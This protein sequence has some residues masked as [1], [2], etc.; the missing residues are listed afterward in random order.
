[1][2]KTIYATM[3]FLIQIVV[4]GQVPEVWEPR[5]IGGG[6]ALFAPAV[7]PSNTDEYYVACDMSEQFHTTDFGLS[8]SN[9]DFTQLTAFNSSKVWFTS[10]PGLLYSINFVT[11]IAQVARSTDN[12]T[13]WNNVA[14]NL[15]WEEVYALYVDYDHPDILVTNFWSSVLVSKNGGESFSTVYETE[16]DPGA[17]LAGVFFD[18]PDIFIG[19]NEG[20]L[21]SHDGGDSFAFETFQGIP[22]GQ[23]FY[24]FAGAKQ[25][26]TLRFF[27]ATAPINDFW[28]SM[29]ASEYW[30]TIDGIYRLDYGITNWEAAITGIDFAVD[31]PMLVAM[32]ANDIH[33]VFLGGS[34]ADG[35]PDV[36]KTTNGGN[37]W[38]HVFLTA[39]N[40]NI[41]TGWSGDGG[42]H[43]WWYPEIILGI[44][45]ARFNPDIVI[46]TDLGTI[47]KTDNGGDLWQ[48]AYVSVSDQHLAGS[49]T[50][51]DQNY[52][53][54]GIENTGAWCMVWSDTANIF[55]GY[56]DISGLRS[57][58]G[59]QSWSFDYTGHDQ[60]TMYCTVRHP[61]T[62]TI[63]AATST[64]HDMY[65]SYKLQDDEIEFEGSGGMV[66]FS[67]D[68]GAHWEVLHD[69]EMP[70]YWVALDPGDEEKL[71]AAVVNHSDGLGGIWM[72]GNLS[73]AAA[74]TWQKLPDP[75]RT[76]GHPATMIV[77]N[78]GKLLTSWSGRRDE[79]GAFTNSSGIFI[80]NPQTQSWDDRS[81]P[82]MDYWTKDVV[83]DPSDLQQ[84]TW[85]AGV[86]SGWGGPA[87]DK[88]GLYRTFD[89]GLS[90]ERVWNTHRVESCTFN[91]LN[92]DEIFITTETKG[93]WHCENINADS[94]IIER[95]KNYNF[96]HPVRVVYNPYNSHEIWV[97]S[98][99]NGMKTG[100]ATI[101]LQQQT[102][103]LQQGW[104]GISSFVQPSNTAFEQLFANVPELLFL[105]DGEGFYQPG[106][107]GN[108]IQNW[109]NNK[110]YLVKMSEADQMIFEGNDPGAHS[111]S[112]VEGWNLIPVLSS[113]PVNVQ[114]M[115]VQ[116][117][118]VV[119]VK[120]VAGTAVFWPGKSIATLLFLLPGKSYFLKADEMFDLE[121][122]NLDY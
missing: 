32:A 66:I 20:L 15:E 67:A 82:N 19:L 81:D 11:D 90:W 25:N 105:S 95:V 44:D 92:P 4:S 60:N 83:T 48:Q 97:L 78:D 47:H 28:N 10:T 68:K 9:V 121:F 39:N 53:S 74:S 72:T 69:F 118:H 99:G 22:D 29:P 2:T 1:M 101:Q 58:D 64:V 108:T 8:Y 86:F 38:Q 54:I 89:R 21:V 51:K 120:D 79:S 5:G 107:A 62:G 112:V 103:D 98:F 6:G 71:Y 55:A 77:L 114:Q 122:D 59:G 87:N 104:S 117:P 16:I 42:D 119:A 23:G 91:P 34:N 106:S 14:G 113:Q 110:G 49:S 93:L 37:S 50:P 96:M 94:P 57:K 100:Y 17:H 35:F 109:N 36:L 52:H 80:Y 7:N 75:P 31:Y 85:Y 40:Q 18:Y 46:V 33:T 13:T 102:V 61:V 70:V 3:F 45:V 88:G 26:D 116:Y 43:Q 73:A 63:F 27:V 56:T 12:G 76:E 84:N 111:V 65:Q 115:I 41:I 30:E 24:S